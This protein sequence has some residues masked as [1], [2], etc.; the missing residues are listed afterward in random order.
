M[1]KTRKVM[2]G[3]TT[4]ALTMGLAGCSSGAANTPPSPPNNK[5]CDEWD[6]D[7]DDGVWECEDSHSNHYGHY[8]H[9]GSYYR[10]KNALLKSKKYIDYKKSSSFQ[11]GSSKKSSSGFGSGSKSFGG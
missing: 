10:S 11:G 4:T 3:I 6:W 1:G 5:D 7:Q 8:Y 2:V 9:G